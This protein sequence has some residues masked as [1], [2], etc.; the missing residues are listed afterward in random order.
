[1]TKL[2][3]NRNEKYLKQDIRKYHNNHFHDNAINRHA[4]PAI[5]HMGYLALSMFLQAATQMSEALSQL[6]R[7]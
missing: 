6:C 1:M 2:H 4:S 5:R 7:K 3:K